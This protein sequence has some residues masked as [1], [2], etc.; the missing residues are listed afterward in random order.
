M[1]NYKDIKVMVIDVDGTMTDAGIYYDNKGNELKK[2]CSKDACGFF[3]AH[4]SGLK[5]MVL[6][7]RECSAV[8]KRMKELKVDFIYQN[9]K[10]KR[11]FLLEFMKREN[12]KPEN[13]GY[14]GD[15][16]NDYSAM[17]MA[18][19]RA[20]PKDACSEVKTICNYVSEVRGG[21]GAVRDIIEYF[22]KKLNMWESAVKKVYMSDN[23]ED[24]YEA[25]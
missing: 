7:G 3:T 14:I 20:C 19:F 4:A 8:T 16:L 15:D 10:E 5:L 11:L 6:T 9:V 13:I 12:L 18:G 24:Y 25:K 2:F 21:E 17:T 1:G 23:M 22:L